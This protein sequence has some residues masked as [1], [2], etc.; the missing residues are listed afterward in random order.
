MF[1]LD[2]ADKLLAPEFQEN[3]NLIYSK[4]PANKQM[5][6]FSA[7]YPS[8]MGPYVTRYMRSPTYVRLN[9]V[10]PSLRGIK[11][12]FKLTPYSDQSSVSFDYKVESL[13]DLLSKIQFQQSIIFTN[14]QMK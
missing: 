1:I 6:C 3:I 7:T 13:L 10:D 8:Y 2:E 11:Q 5:L 14:Y 4:L 9:I 12:Y